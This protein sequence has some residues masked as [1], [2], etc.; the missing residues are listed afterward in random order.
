VLV[1]ETYSIYV[2]RNAWLGDLVCL[3]VMEDKSCAKQ[4]LVEGATALKKDH[5][6]DGR[7]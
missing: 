2:I 7:R 3:C 5:G 1:V 4:W 6:M